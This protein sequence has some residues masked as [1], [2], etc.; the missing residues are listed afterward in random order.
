MGAQPSVFQGQELADSCLSESEFQLLGVALGVDTTGV[1]PK[2]GRALRV[3]VDSG[4]DDGGVLSG[5]P[6]TTV[7]LGSPSC[8]ALST[9]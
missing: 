4:V 3:K 9:S 8:V 2:L 1:L 5:E 6:S 7:T